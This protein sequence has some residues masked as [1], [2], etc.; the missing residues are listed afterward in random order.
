MQLAVFV[1]PQQGADYDTLCRVAQHAESLGF[2]AF[3]R[4]DHYLSFGPGE[5][6]P[7]PTDAWVT[8][9]ALAVQTSTIRLGTLVS[10]AT[11]RLPGPLAITVAQVDA[12]SGGRVTFGLGTGWYDAEHT[13]Y[14]IPFP[15]LGER[16]DRL[17]EQLQI[18]IGLWSTPLGETFHFAGRHYQLSRSPG[19]PK[20]VQKPHPPVLIGGHGRRRTPA[21]AAAYAD[22]INVP[23]GSVAD[24]RAVFA[25]TT[26]ACESLGRDLTQRPLARSAAQTIACGR[27]DDA[28]KRRAE[29]IGQTPP[30]HG[31]PDRVVA[32]LGEFADLGCD[33]VMLQILNLA[34]LDH[35]DVIAADVL[36]QLA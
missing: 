20:P 35:L 9:A 15:P 23:F 32:Q 13:A 29:T 21:L 17:E 28:A 2:P 36:P 18:V 4:S 34:D 3:F 26:E 31:T 27:T 5:G 7:G 12:M 22:E 25:A 6:R 30:I 11:F 19:L 1:E 10:S 24:T 33:R 16:F 8:L 14:G